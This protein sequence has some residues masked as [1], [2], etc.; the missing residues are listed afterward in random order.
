MPG[1]YGTFFI[2]STSASA[3]FIGLL[4]VAVSIA[5]TLDADY[6]NRE[7]R[8]V[9]AG[10]SFLA[11]VD[12]FFVSIVTLTDGVLGLCIMSIVMGVIGLLVTSHLMPRARRAGNFARGFP[13]RRVN[14][15]FATVAISGYSI[16]LGLGIALV[17]QQQNDAL[18]RSLVLTMVALFGSAL[19]RAWE[20]T[21][22]ADQ[23]ASGSPPAEVR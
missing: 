5:H 23:R 10:S 22:I 4:F 19:T 11:L 13:R 21:W 6:Q 15:A 17:V 8:L 3:G 16:Q 7:R 18:I 20:M 12:N 2:S 1:G 14:L 9:L